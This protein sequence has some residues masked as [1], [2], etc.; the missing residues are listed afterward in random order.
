MNIIACT[1]LNGHC[2][3]CTDANTCT[4]CSG[5][6]FGY[7][8]T[9]VTQCPGNTYNDGVM[10]IGKAISQSKILKFS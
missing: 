7:G 3:T 1:T 10:C 2:T 6:R 4:S 8:L 9:C 5:G